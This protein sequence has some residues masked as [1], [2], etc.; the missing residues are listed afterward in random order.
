MVAHLSGGQGVVGSNPAS[1]TNY[2]NSVGLHWR[3]EPR[4][5]LT[6]QTV[7]FRFQ[8]QLITYFVLQEKDTYEKTQTLP[9]WYL[10]AERNFTGLEEFVTRWLD[11][12]VL[13]G[14]I[15]AA[16]R[17]EILDNMGHDTAV[18]L[19]ATASFSTRS[20][21]LM[22]DWVENIFSAI[23]VETP[24]LFRDEYIEFMEA[25]QLAKQQ[26]SS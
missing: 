9:Q 20:G 24:W 4:G 14:T 11:L 18:G 15:T 5:Y 23:A 8:K 2:I 10:E 1:P 19:W 26:R 25:Q 17:A 16:K 13:S 21:L 22:P 6:Q 7:L 3:A 12:L